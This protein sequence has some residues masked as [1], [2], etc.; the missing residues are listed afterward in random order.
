LAPGFE[1]LSALS[2]VFKN[3]GPIFIVNELLMLWHDG[4]QPW[5]RKAASVKSSKM[6]ELQDQQADAR[7]TADA[8]ADPFSPT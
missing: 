1:K 8:R 2:N 6:N 5:P 4:G 3:P 7:N